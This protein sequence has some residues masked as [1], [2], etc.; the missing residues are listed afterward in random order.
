MKLIAGA[1]YTH[2]K[3]SAMKPNM[4]EGATSLHDYCAEEVGE[5]RRPGVR[6]SCETALGKLPEPVMYF[7]YSALTAHGSRAPLFPRCRCR[8]Q[9]MTQISANKGTSATNCI[10]GELQ[11]SD[12]GL[13]ALDLEGTAEGVL[14]QWETVSMSCG[15]HS[16]IPD[17]FIGSKA[18]LDTQNFTGSNFDM[19]GEMTIQALTSYEKI[20]WSILISSY[21][22][23]CMEGDGPHPHRGTTH[24]ALDGLVMLLDVL[25]SMTHLARELI[26]SILNRSLILCLGDYKGSR[27]FERPTPE[28][29]QRHLDEF[30]SRNT[31][32]AA[33]H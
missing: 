8:P 1:G 27:P 2:D 24:R 7:G 10:A 13:P 28:L 14:N 21:K 30:N 32:G 12:H 11:K 3:P 18:L 5:R 16:P 6:R 9:S 17:L 19:T 33:H 15:Q 29:V 26:I 4:L 23:V 25:A 31:N 20:S 22:V